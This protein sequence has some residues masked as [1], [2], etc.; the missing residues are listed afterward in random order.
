MQALFVQK[1]EK[2]SDESDLDVF[3]TWTLSSPLVQGKTLYL[4]KYF[5]P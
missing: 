1:Q 3:N 2:V 5:Q 4:S